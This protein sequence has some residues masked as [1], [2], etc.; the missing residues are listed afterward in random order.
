MDDPLTAR[1]AATVRNTRA[2][3]GL[4]VLAL[5]ERSGVS[6][7]MIG[8]IERAEVQPTAALL[9]RLSGAL[10]LTLSELIS[11]AEGDDRRVARAGD[12]PVWIDPETGYRRRDLSPPT[13]GPLD[14][15]W[16]ELPPGARVEYPAAAFAFIHQQIW[17]IDGTLHFEE[18]GHVHELDAGDCLQIGPPAPC[19]FVNARKR[20]CHY[21]VAT[22][23][24]TARD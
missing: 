19:A 6:R 9:G 22:M 10:G 7:A 20:P 3:R 12:Q 17:V 2:S 18:G 5:A 8:K 21:L 1:L 13:G 16:V 24:R 23:K 14:M 4:S 15:V 11:R